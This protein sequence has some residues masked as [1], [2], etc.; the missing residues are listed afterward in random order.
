VQSKGF[1]PIAQ[2]SG[3]LIAYATAEVEFASDVGAHA[4]PYARALAEEIVRPGIESVIMF[5]VRA[6]IQHDSPALR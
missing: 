1:V 4:G 2:E 5:R 6:A 3:M